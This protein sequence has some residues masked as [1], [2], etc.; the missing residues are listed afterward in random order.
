MQYLDQHLKN[1]QIGKFCVSI[2]SNLNRSEMAA[3]EQYNSFSW[4]QY[5][6]SVRFGIK[7]STED[8]TNFREIDGR[9]AVSEQIS[10][11]IFLV[12]RHNPTSSVPR[13]GRNPKTM[14]WND[15]NHS[16]QTTVTGN[17]TSILIL[18]IYTVKK[19]C[20]LTR[21]FQ[22]WCELRKWHRCVTRMKMAYTS[23]CIS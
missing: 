21:Y 22:R 17:C 20:S 3:T 14:C 13:Y 12:F 15:L 6:W 10:I 2:I 4:S 9:S 5:P 19:T 16:L 1:P 7:A 8:R 18:L 11:L 23:A